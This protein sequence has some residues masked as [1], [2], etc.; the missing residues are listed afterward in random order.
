MVKIRDIISD[1]VVDR[2]L[3][4]RD[5]PCIAF[6][7]KNIYLRIEVLIF[8]LFNDGRLFTLDMM[9]SLLLFFLFLFC[10]FLGNLFGLAASGK[11][12]G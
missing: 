5:L 2:N 4:T 8:Y 1:A 10:R 9:W 6:L 12:N 7:D 3:I 11:E